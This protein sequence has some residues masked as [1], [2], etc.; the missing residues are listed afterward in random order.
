MICPC[1]QSYHRRLEQMMSVRAIEKSNPPWASLS[2]KNYLSVERIRVIY[3][4]SESSKIS[5]DYFCET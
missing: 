1:H 3:V 4:M 2:F 5:Y